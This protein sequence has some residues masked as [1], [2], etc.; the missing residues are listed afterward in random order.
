MRPDAPLRT[1][2]I[3]DLP[4][5]GPLP[6]WR[7]AL[8]W[9]AL[10]PLLLALLLPLGNGR[11]L[12]CLQASL[13]G[14]LGGVAWYLGNCYWIYQT[15]YLYGGLPKPVA[16]LILVLFAF[17]LGLY[18]ALFGALIALV[19]QSTY[20]MQ[21]A[22]F[23]APFL[24]VAVEFARARVTGFPWD[25]LGN[26]QVDN[27][28]LTRL[29]PATGVTGLSFVIVAANA[30][31]VSLWLNRKMKPGRL[32]STI[33][34]LALATEAGSLL[35]PIR[36]ADL[37]APTEKVV[38]MQENL[39]VGAVGRQIRPLAVDQE[40]QLFTDASEHPQVLPSTL[41]TRDLVPDREAAPPKLIIWP[42]APSHLRSDDLGTR[43]QLS[44]LAR[45]VQA[46]LIIGSL[47][48]DLDNSVARGYYLYDSATLL[49]PEGTYSGRYDK[50][51]LVPWGEY[52]PFK[53]FFAFAQKLTEGV[54]DMD[55]GRDRTVFRTG[56]H[57][58]GV[59]I[60]YESI[61]G[62]E[63]REFVQRGADVLVNIS[64]DG[65]YGDTGAPWQHLN[66]TRMRAIENHRWVLLDTN[67]GITSVI[68]PRG[69]LSAQAPRHSR[70]A[71]AMLFNY[72]DRLTFYTRFG[73]WFAWLCVTVT[74]ALAAFSWKARMH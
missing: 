55:R 68:D 29:A 23:G 62:D 70:A 63:V 51:H 8:C 5:A 46:P 30:A 24:W 52:V 26:S 21:A 20:G 44:D 28:L 53:Q 56:G 71:Y 38:M 37:T 33:V 73:D 66:M 54:G 43:A 47:G 36:Q 59:F 1:S 48:V 32:A 65:W 74:A 13:L 50:I 49:T 39:E 72:S 69:R 4:I 67:T 14:Y 16:V 64:D 41:V 7:A 15:M 6:A 40:L 12:S 58:Y 31:I 18:H 27:L 10:V 57:A 35:N 11:P 25:L 9:I 60:C 17:Y 2:S 42:E 34:V 61:F 19:R 22:L 45:H 3:P